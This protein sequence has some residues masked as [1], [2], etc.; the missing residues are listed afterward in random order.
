MLNS[1]QI[2][3]PEN[4]DNYQ[5]DSPRLE[6]I[7]NQEFG[8]DSLDSV[9]KK[10]LKKN[11]RVLESYI[12]LYSNSNIRP[13]QTR[14]ALEKHSQ[15]ESPNSMLIRDSEELKGHLSFLYEMAYSHYILAKAKG[16]KN[17]QFPNKCCGRSTRNLLLSAFEHGYS[18]AVYAYNDNLDHAQLMLPFKLDNSKINGAILVDPTS[19]QFNYDRNSIS[20]K[21]SSS[22]ENVMD[23][24]TPNS[25]L[26]IDLVKLYGLTK[27]PSLY[28]LGTEEFMEECFRNSQRIEIPKI[29]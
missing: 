20:I 29:N 16:L 2:I 27:K 19:D 21:L 17:N 9:E 15:I 14:K 26:S 28:H 18:N 1:S 8:I 10:D 7:L 3:L 12:P 11:K 23:V 24:Q 13:F 6:L 4:L 5:L 22:W 25:Y